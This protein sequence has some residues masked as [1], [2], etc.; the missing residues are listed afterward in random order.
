MAPLLSSVAIQPDDDGPTS[1]QG[2]NA[3][4]IPSLRKIEIFSWS[5][6]GARPKDNSSDSAY[7]SLSSISSFLSASSDLS[8][9]ST[10]SSFDKPS[11]SLKPLTI[12]PPASFGAA[13]PAASTDV[14]STI[15]STAATMPDLFSPGVMPVI[16]RPFPSHELIHE[17]KDP[18]FLNEDLKAVSR[19]GSVTAKR[20]PDQN[21]AKSPIR[22]TCKKP[23]R[24]AIMSSSDP[25]RTRKTL[26]FE[27]KK[28]SLFALALKWSVG[29]DRERRSSKSGRCYELW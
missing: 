27:C 1:M 29:D 8:F 12:I 3:I 20:T 19:T 17:W 16:E 2:G 10:S 24:V 23:P 25:L 5:G 21:Q 26:V 22:T 15:V 13:L 7:S 28:G 9:A 11:R 14:S 6:L 18:C 4:D